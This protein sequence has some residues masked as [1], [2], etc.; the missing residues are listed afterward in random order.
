MR[1][2]LVIFCFNPLLQLVCWSQRII[3]HFNARN[4]GNTRLI[5]CFSL[6]NLKVVEFNNVYDFRDNGLKSR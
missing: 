1:S 2:N 4:I 6:I 5:G 3:A